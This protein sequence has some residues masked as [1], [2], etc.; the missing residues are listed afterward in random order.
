MIIGITLMAAGL[1]L[2]TIG[3]TIATI[4][5]IVFSV[6]GYVVAQILWDMTLAKIKKLE[7]RVF[8]QENSKK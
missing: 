5:G 3:E 7:Y 6:T 2:F 8:E 1:A 4:F